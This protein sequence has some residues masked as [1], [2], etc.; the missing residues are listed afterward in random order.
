MPDYYTEQRPWGSFTILYETPT[1]KVKKIRVKPG[2]RLSY[3]THAKRSEHWVVVEGQ[4][5]VILN[6]AE[7]ILSVGE[8]IDVPVGAKHRFGATAEGEMVLI[9]VQ[10]GDYLGEDDIVRLQDDYQRVQ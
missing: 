4:A 6:D 9:E 2:C 3:Q 10:R 1:L 5:R 7:V 8:S